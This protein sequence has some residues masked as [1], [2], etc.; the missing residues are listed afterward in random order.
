MNGPFR[1][2]ARQGPAAAPEATCAEAAGAGLQALA[3][4]ARS[5]V[6]YDPGN[7][8]VRHH[9]ADYQSKMCGALQ[10]HGTIVIGVGPFHLAVAGHVVYEERDREKSLAFRLYRDGVRTVRMLSHAPWE[11]L[12]ELL[13]IVAVR[14]AAVREQEEDTVTLLRRAE[15]GGIEFDS[16]EGFVPAEEIPEP[17]GDTQVERARRAKPAAGWDTPLQKLPVP[18]PVDYREV[19]DEDLAALRDEMG[20]DAVGELATSLARDLLAEATR[21]GWPMPNRDLIAFFSEVRDGLLVDGELAAMRALIDVLTLAGA[22]DLRDL[23]LRGLGD[24]RTLDMV[25]EAVPDDSDK[26]PAQLVPFLPLLGVD[27]ALDRLATPLSDARRELLVKVVLARLPRETDLVLARLPAL[28]AGIVR[29]LAHGIVTRA[30]ER[31]GEVVRQLLAQGDEALRIEGLNAVEAAP[32]TI[33]LRPLA[34][35]LEDRS[36]A[37]RVRA[38][39]VLGRRGDESVIDI[40][41]AALQ[42]SRVPSNR[43]AEA[44]GRSLAQLAP[45][46]AAQM[47]LT[48]LEVKGGFLRRP[49]PQQR[50]RQWAAVAGTGVLP[51]ADAENALRLMAARSEGD[52]RRHCLAALARRRK[53]VGGR[54]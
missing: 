22:G 32:D 40:L 49:S 18:G 33:P 17:E 38:A 54:G 52:L 34:V 53:E 16:V 46:R 30:P 9:L 14:Y 39:E 44:L 50:A 23:M 10:A 29:A 37:V 42:S 27:A 28:E 43:E 11:E 4:A 48:W 35:L 7:D 19:P 5:I 51:G 21:A 26:L 12:L 6:L 31:A 36:E 1:S 47:F 24:A 15:F 3:R 20:D 41:S 13:Q 45:I 2:S 8:T 25:L